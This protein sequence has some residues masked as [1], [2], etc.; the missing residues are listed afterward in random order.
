[1]KVI[2]KFHS[3]KASLP[4]FPKLC[5][6]FLSF[7]LTNMLLERFALATQFIALRIH[8]TLCSMMESR[9]KQKPIFIGVLIDLMN[10]LHTM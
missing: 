6:K 4:T 5:V 2:T 10:C 8:S 3:I 7:F 1:M 9:V